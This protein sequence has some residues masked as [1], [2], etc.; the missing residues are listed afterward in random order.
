M[1]EYIKSTDKFGED[2]YFVII[3]FEPEIGRK[4]SLLQSDTWRY[5]A[6]TRLIIEEKTFLKGNRYKEN[7]IFTGDIYIPIKI[8]KEMIGYYYEIE[9]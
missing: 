2:Y 8:Q 9:I 4:L 1:K 5:Y 3:A 7:G 6:E